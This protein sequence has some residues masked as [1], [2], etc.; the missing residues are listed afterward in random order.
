MVHR[1]LLQMS[2]DALN[3]AET[4]ARTKQTAQEQR[5]MED[6]D[7]PTCWLDLT[8]MLLAMMSPFACFPNAV[9]IEW[10]IQVTARS[11]TSNT[12]SAPSAPRC[13]TRSERPGAPQDR[14]L[15]GRPS[16]SRQDRALGG[17][18]TAPPRATISERPAPEST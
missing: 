5:R 12:D 1:V 7:F 4:P 8:G 11:D 9:G 16:T 2:P 10:L 13:G 17:R 15:G 6:D 3:D 18:P 14:T